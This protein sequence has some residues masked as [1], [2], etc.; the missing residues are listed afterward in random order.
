MLRRCE[1]MTGLTGPFSWFDKLACFGKDFAEAIGEP[2]EM[3]ACMG[4]RQAATENLEYMLS[5]N[6]G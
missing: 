3:F 1:R 5:R 2:I 4:R 6:D